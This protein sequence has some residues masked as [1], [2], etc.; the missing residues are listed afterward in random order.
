MFRLTQRKR[1]ARGLVSLICGL[2]LTGI[3][4][5]QGFQ[6]VVLTGDALY[7]FGIAAGDFD[8]DGDLDAATT[9]YSAGT[10]LWIETVPAGPSVLHSLY[11]AMGRLR[12]L[13]SA[14]FDSDGD[15]DF[16]VASYDENRFL[17]LENGHQ[18][19]LDTFYV[20]ILREACNGAWGVVAAD[21]DEDGDADLITTEFNSNVARI[22]L[23]AEGA[24]VEA[25]AFQTAHPMDATA[26]DYDSDGDR[27]VVV[28]S[29]E[30][31]FVWCE[32]TADGWV[33]HELGIGFNLTGV[34]AA[35]LDG[36][37]DVDLIGTPFLTGTSILWWERTSGGFIQHT[38]P[39]QLTY[40]RDVEATDFDNDGDLDIVVSA[41]D[42]QL[43]WW[44][45]TNTGFELRQATN[46]FS[47][48][49]LMTKDFDQDGDT[50]ILAADLQG[51]RVLFYR[52]TMGIP[53][54][55]TGTVRSAAEDL[56]IA[57]VLVRLNETGASTVT[58]AAGHYTIY[59]A[60]GTYTVSTLH[61]CWNDSALP[62]VEGVSGETTTL[63]I[64]LV[65]P[66]VGLDM[67]S[68]NL[69]VQNGD[70]VTAQLP[71]ANT[72]DGTMVVVAG[73]EGNY[74][75]DPWLAVTPDSVVIPSG[76]EFSFTI[77]VTPDTTFD[78]NWDYLGQVNF[79]TN[80]CPDSDLTVMVVLYVLETPHPGSELPK[81]IALNDVY[82]NPF[83]ANAVI[84]FELPVRQSI[85]VELMDVIGRHVQTLA[86]GFYEAGE[87]K[88]NIAGAD[89]ASGVYFVTLQ[90][91]E[92][93]LT[94]KALLLK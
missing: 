16:A 8:G 60:A 6:Q 72:G 87:H 27:D 7:A 4:G 39:G 74:A 71:I 84:Q 26:A 93:R 56:P 19:G 46:G 73:V 76:G 62:S 32:Q 78:F 30:D 9:D 41:Q 10:I 65:R 49:C 25:T 43:R 20:R 47:L 88:L 57:Q 23:Q 1:S 35:D 21:L 81:T 63:D 15:T 28:G 64:T 75:N 89:L 91:P 5:A 40:P 24:L 33:S 45:R 69:L 36:D 11:V 52:N 55:V 38:L 3:A 59:A 77:H 14:D 67:S 50:D 82:P 48:Y 42:G 79:R 53:A 86:S 66:V 34:A 12:G 54:I 13:T 80:A 17:W 94:R 83:N 61:P 29:Y 44:E 18:Q 31:G 2:C 70:S 92:I 37:D 85:T 51:T 68:I 90:T 22:F 58:D